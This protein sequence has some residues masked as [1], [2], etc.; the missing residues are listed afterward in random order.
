MNI[1]GDSSQRIGLL[2][3][4]CWF[5]MTIF[6]QNPELSVVSFFM[7][8]ATPWNI[9]VQLTAHL[10]FIANGFELCSVGSKE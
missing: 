2:I 4:P 6:L 9:S 10:F 5:K 8:L 7:L 1:S 3:S